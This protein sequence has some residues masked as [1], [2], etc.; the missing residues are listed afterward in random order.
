MGLQ[1]R[2]LFAPV[3]IVDGVTLYSHSKAVLVVASSLG[4]FACGAG[5]E[6]SPDAVPP[7]AATPKPSPTPTPDP[8]LGLAAGPVASYVIEVRTVNNGERDALP[9][10][11]GRLSVYPGE[12]VDFDSTQKNA[13]GEICRWN[14][15]PQWFVDG[16]NIPLETLSGPVYRRGSSQPFL[17]KLTI[18]H[19]GEFEVQ[20]EIDGIKSNI[21]VMTAR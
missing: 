4:L 15:D 5:S 8:R 10:A 16:V 20:A 12:R 3:A 9:D 17:L 21:L 2:F 11:D 18:E 6:S 1:T 13:N 7:Q 14:T 19:R